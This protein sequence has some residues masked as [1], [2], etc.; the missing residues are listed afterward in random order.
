M[1]NKNKALSKH[2]LNARKIKL[3][4]DWESYFIFV[5]PEIDLFY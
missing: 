3:A 2:A 5:V 1:D 4:G